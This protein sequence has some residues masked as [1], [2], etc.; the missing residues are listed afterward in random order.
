MKNKYRRRQYNSN[1]EIDFIEKSPIRIYS[2][3]KFKV[4][5]NVKYVE[6]GHYDYRLICI[7][8]AILLEIDPSIYQKYKIKLNDGRV[9]LVDE[10]SIKRIKPPTEFDNFKYKIGQEIYYQI[11]ASFQMGVV[12]NII[13]F[14]DG[15]IYYEFICNS[16]GNTITLHEIDI[17]VKTILKRGLKFNVGDIVCERN[18]MKECV[19]K[20]FFSFTYPYE[21]N[22]MCEIETNGQ[23]KIVYE[24]NLRKMPLIVVSEMDPYGE[25]DWSD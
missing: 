15:S 16:N 12:S 1:K 24:E 7:Y 14:Q 3:G 5:E 18:I 8:D 9:E 17:R 25:E 6:C 22:T 10:N 23:M 19:I 11:Y 4:G 21:Y 2:D 20:E 13:S